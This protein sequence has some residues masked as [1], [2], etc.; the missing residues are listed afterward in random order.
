MKYLGNEQDLN[1][2]DLVKLL[3]DKDTS[4]TGRL[5][6]SD[7]SKWLGSA[8]HMSESF[9]FRHDSKKNPEFNLN[10]ARDIKNKGADKRNAQ[11]CLL[12]GDNEVRILEKIKI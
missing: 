2:N 9:I 4:K 5:N 12:K 11:Q 1:Y 8:I 3:Y 6:Y 10:L 7:F